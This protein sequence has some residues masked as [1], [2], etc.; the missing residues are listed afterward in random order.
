MPPGTG[1]MAIS[2]GQLLP[3]AEVLVV[4][5]PQPLAQEV[6]A[7]AAMMAQKTGQKLL[8]VVENMSGDAF[9]RAA[10]SRLADELDVALLGTVPLDRRCGR[11]ATP[12]LPSS[13]PIPTPSRRR[14]SSR[15]R[16]PFC[17][18]A[19]RDPQ[20]ADAPL[21]ERRRAPAGALLPSLS[22]ETC[23]RLRT[24]VSTQ[25]PPIWLQ[26]ISTWSPALTRSTSSSSLTVQVCEA[27]PSFGLTVIEVGLT[28]RSDRERTGARSGAAS[29]R[30]AVG[31]PSRSRR[32]SCR[33]RCR[34]RRRSGRPSSRTS[35]QGCRTAS[36]SPRP[37]VP[38]TQASSLPSVL[39]PEMLACVRPSA[40]PM[41][42]QTSTQP[43][44]LVVLYVL[45]TSVD[46][47]RSARWWC[48]SP[49][50]TSGRW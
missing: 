23:Y 44:F 39:T 16:R 14:R 46:R 1:D 43:S 34:S 26:V 38:R 10:A 19:G 4:T 22:R 2:L 37:A 9:G 30:V 48:S 12:A 7:R 13:S 3:R 21:L 40:A 27:E 17:H 45:L 24:F 5:T 8:G 33:C 50:P 11:P 42:S 49:C 41:F 6:A 20:A 29:L 36:P 31:C 32:R 18:P 15:S 47:A 25:A 28:V 35:R